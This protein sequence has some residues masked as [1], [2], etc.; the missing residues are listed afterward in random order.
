MGPVGHLICVLLRRRVAGGPFAG[1]KYLAESFGSAYLP[2]LLGTYEKELWGS[3]HRLISACQGGTMINVGAAEGY[4]AVGAMY[5]KAFTRVVC[6]EQAAQARQL[7]GKLAKLNGVDQGLELH[8]RCDPVI[9]RDLL[10]AVSGPVAIVCD[11]EGHEDVLLNPIVNE[12][13]TQCHLLVETHEDW[14]PGVKERLRN[15]FEATH[16]IEMI[17]AVARTPADLAVRSWLLA[18]FPRR[19]KLRWLD[20]M[21]DI[22]TPWFLMM[23]R[24]HTARRP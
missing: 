14:C 8:E 15:R 18:Q 17:P 20:E 12:E 2:K 9:L 3:W 6:Y 13:L 21:R 10:R 5:S 7:L 4:Y 22:D 19:N 11:V 1:M 23:P 24:R 16:D